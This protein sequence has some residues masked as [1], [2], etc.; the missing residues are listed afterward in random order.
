MYL[1]C[2]QKQSLYFDLSLGLILKNL[3]EPIRF[4]ISFTI[5][6]QLPGYQLKIST[7]KKLS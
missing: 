4:V 5:V 6:D 3:S 1:L 2:Q 7:P